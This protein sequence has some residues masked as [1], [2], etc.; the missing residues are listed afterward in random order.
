MAA[1]AIKKHRRLGWQK[2]IGVSACRRI[3][4]YRKE[5]VS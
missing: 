2:R 4:E 3:G 1:T 5:D